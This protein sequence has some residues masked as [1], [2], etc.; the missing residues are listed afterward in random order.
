MICALHSSSALSVNVFS[1]WKEGRDLGT[2]LAALN[3]LGESGTLE[4]ERK[5]PRRSQHATNLDV[6]ITSTGGLV[7]GVGC[8]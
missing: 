4:F 1:Y 7:V 8:K 2:L 5:S 3:I 6:F